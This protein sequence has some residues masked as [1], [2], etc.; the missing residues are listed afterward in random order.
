[1]AAALKIFGLNCSLK[2]S[3][4]DETSSTDVLMKQLYDALGDHGAA[5][6]FVRA[7]DYDIK[8]GVKSDEGDGDQWP[9]LRKRI[10]DADI[11]VLG[12]PV[13][14]G[15][16]SSIAKRVVERMDAFLGETDDRGRMPAFGK[17]AICVSVGNEDGAHHVS[18]DVLQ[19]LFDVGFTIPANPV[20]Y[21]VGEAMGSV[22]YKDLKKVPDKVAQVN[23]MLASNAAHLARLLKAENYPGVTQDK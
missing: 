19:A 2:S 6:D 16:A 10:L 22:D 18:A 15:Q 11:F 14:M 9:E 12:S 13:W 7:A 20:T 5:G 1:M 3:Q 4:A 8:P 23:A 21:W 17:V